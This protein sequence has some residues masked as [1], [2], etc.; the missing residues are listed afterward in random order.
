[1]EVATLLALSFAFFLATRLLAR[2]VAFHAVLSAMALT[3]G[4][5]LPLLAMLGTAIYGAVIFLSPAF[6]ETMRL[7]LLSC[8]GPEALW[9]EYMTLWRRMT[10]GDIEPVALVVIMFQ[11]MMGLGLVVV[12]TVYTVAFLR[13]L[14][15]IG[16]AGT[17]RLVAIAL[18]GI[19]LGSVA[20]AMTS[21][22]GWMIGRGMQ[23]CG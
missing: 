13:S 21:S 9:A 3:W 15:R 5:A 4:A 14:G 23:A 18:T 16:Q 19:V 6:F 12:C 17:G 20:L 8:A 10:G 1:V 11:L 7:F 22:F 2:P